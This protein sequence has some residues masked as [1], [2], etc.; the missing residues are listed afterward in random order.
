MSMS[1]CNHAFT[2]FVNSHFFSILLFQ[3]RIKEILRANS[4]VGDRRQY[5]GKDNGL[6]IEQISN[7]CNRTSTFRALSAFV[8]SC[9]KE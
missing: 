5:T 1:V 2:A 3:L 4:S 9:F 7:P 8:I 6:S